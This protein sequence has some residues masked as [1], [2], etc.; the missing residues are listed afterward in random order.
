MC[1]IMEDMRDEKEVRIDNALRMIKNGE[2]SV[3]KIALYPGLS[4]DEAK[5][6][7]A[8]VMA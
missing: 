4:V 6:L 3:R 2:L 7:A 8:P 5:G 1:R